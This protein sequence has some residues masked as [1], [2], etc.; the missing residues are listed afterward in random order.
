M[1]PVARRWCFADQLGPHFLDQPDQPVLLIESRAVFERRR[2]HRR[3][4]HLVLSALR[5]RAAELGEQALFLQTH[6]YRE[7]LDQVDG[8][9]SV[10]Q[11]TSWAADRFVRSLPHVEVLP[12]RGFCTSREEFEKWAGRSRKLLLE[13]FYRDARRRFDLL[14][15]ADQPAAGRWNFDADNREPPPKNVVAL[16][17]PAPWQPEEDEI[18]ERVRADLDRWERD[19]TVE[20]VGRDGPREFAVTAQEAQSAFSVFLR[21]R[22]PHF[23]P[24]EDAML[25]GDRFLA[26]SLLSASMNLGLLDPLECAYAAE[27]AY[28]AGDAPLASVE[29]YIRQLIGWRDYIWHVYWHFGW[30]YRRRNALK[31]AAPLPD[32]FA[33]LDADAVQARCLK[34]VLG[35]VRDHGWVHHIPRLM[36]LSNYAL[37]RGWNPAAMTDWFH[38][39]FVDGYDWVMVANVVGMSQHA[40][41]GLMATKPYAAGG[42]YINRMSDYCPKCPYHPGER[43]GERACP[44]TGGYWWFLNR[45]RDSLAGN[46]RMNQPLAGMHRLTDLDE[47]VEQQRRLGQSAP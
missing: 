23:G 5:H 16:P 22:L 41:G 8:P 15:E 17:I 37:Q 33:N 45:N 29:G 2:F 42:A 6:T 3:K 4:A 20:F 39:C 43:V 26:H 25:S 11:P 30:D 46:R 7:A 12:P 47:V 1:T 31:A 36:V 13:N 40:D 24:H 38:R 10:C 19:G 21:D 9:L 14:M 44:F 28:R 35:Q 34:D 18:D 27:D 32:W